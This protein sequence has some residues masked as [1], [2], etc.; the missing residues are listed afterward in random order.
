MQNIGITNNFLKSYIQDSIKTK[1]KVSMHQ[2]SKKKNSINYCKIN[3]HI[4]KQ[5]E[6]I[7]NISYQASKS[8]KLII[9]QLNLF[10]E[11]IIMKK[12]LLNNF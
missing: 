5:I 6:I 1:K 9:I 2:I 4:R 3:D 10:F 12:K 11:D 7:L 8:L